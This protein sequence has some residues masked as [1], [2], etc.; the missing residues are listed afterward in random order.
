MASCL[1]LTME[2]QRRHSLPIIF[3]YELYFYKK[4]LLRFFML[5]KNEIIG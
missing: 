2:L 4:S 3:A 5:I 1:G